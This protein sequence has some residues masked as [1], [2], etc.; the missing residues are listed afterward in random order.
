[1]RKD[2]APQPYNRTNKMGEVVAQK[3]RAETAAVHLA[4]EQWGFERGREEERKGEE[5]KWERNER[6]IKSTDRE[7]K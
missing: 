1:M 2:Y 3:S 5:E 7:Y 6:I 4:E